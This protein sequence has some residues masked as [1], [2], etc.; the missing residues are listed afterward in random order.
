M[1]SLI[2]TAIIIATTATSSFAVD[3][4]QR[5]SRAAL[6]LAQELNLSTQVWRGQIGQVRAGVRAAL[7]A[8]F[9]EGAA[10]R[11][12]E[13]DALNTQFSSFQG[14]LYN[15]IN[16]NW[17]NGYVA[18]DRNAT[19]YDLHVAIENGTQARINAATAPLTAQVNT[20]TSDLATA[21]STIASLQSSALAV[22]NDRLVADN[23]RLN[24]RLDN[25]N[26]NLVV[27]V[28]ISLL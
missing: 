7:T 18:F 10:S 2:T 6:A 20:L 24:R 27:Y 25:Y 1:K 13:I 5:Q 19:G 26:N 16:Y 17:G 8:K 15:A 12:G 3:Y 11:Q 23:A 21:N 14:N 28:A 22:E 4:N 9:N